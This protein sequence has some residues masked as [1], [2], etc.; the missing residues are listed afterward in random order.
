MS[1]DRP[2]H[3]SCDRSERTPATGDNVHDLEMWRLR[4]E[5]GK[6][7]PLKSS[8]HN[9]VLALSEHRRLSGLIAFD[10]LS[11]KVWK[12]VTPPWGG[13]PGEWTDY[14]TGECAAFFGDPD[15]DLWSVST[16]L[17]HEAVIVVAKRNPFHPVRQYLE[18]L[19]AWDGVERVP[20]LFHDFFGSESNEYTHAAALSLLVSAVARAI[21]PGCKVDTMVV[22]EG[23][24]GIG[25]SQCIRAL[26]LDEFT[27]EIHGSPTNKDFYQEIQGH[28]AIEIAELQ[29]FSKSEVGHIKA[30]ISRPKDVYRPSYGR[31]AQTFPRQ[32][33]FIGTTNDNQYLRDPTGARRFL[34]VRC[35]ARID[36][37]AIA[38]ARDAL[39]A[40]ALHRYRQ[41]EAWW[42]FPESA[43]KEQARRYQEDPWNEAIAD[44]LE[45][46]AKFEAYEDQAGPINEITTKTLLAK[47]LGVPIPKQTNQDAVRAGKVMQELGWTRH[48]VRRDDRQVWVYQR[49]DESQ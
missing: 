15:N 9:A 22:L 8:M 48:R 46:R 45:G 5:E 36:V 3:P 33:V 6:S 44:Y 39:W 23:S 31:V 2:R 49:P 29:A 41:G 17:L 16:T 1:A 40:E 19:P 28:W 38:K 35:G 4:L 27:V 13:D 32:C 7:G 10:E 47:A 14:D 37:D 25:K 42:K 30:A 24:Q 20:T 43:G 11:G 12:P 18:S 34:P 21:R 26:F